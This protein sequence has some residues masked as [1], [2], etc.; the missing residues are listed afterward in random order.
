MISLLQHGQDSAGGD[1]THV[2]DCE[3]HNRK[4]KAARVMGDIQAAAK[5]LEVETCGE[6]IV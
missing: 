3:H 4:A 5:K 2:H 1:G 6:T